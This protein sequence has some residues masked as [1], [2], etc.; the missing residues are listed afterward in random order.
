LRKQLKEA[1]A[2]LQGQPLA[3]EAAVKARSNALLCLLFGLI[4]KVTKKS[5]LH[6]IE[7]KIYGTLSRAFDHELL[8]ANHCQQKLSKSSTHRPFRKV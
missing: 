1:T 4:Q 8:P 5:R 6:K 3:S 7:L 2:N